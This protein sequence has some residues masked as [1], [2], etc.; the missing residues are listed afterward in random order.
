VTR[1]LYSARRGLLGPGPG[2]RFTDE[3]IR[4]EI[5]TV[6]ARDGFQRALPDVVGAAVARTL[7]GGSV[8]ENEDQM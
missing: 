1:A 5:R 3:E 8:G 2:R 4:A 6:W 7:R